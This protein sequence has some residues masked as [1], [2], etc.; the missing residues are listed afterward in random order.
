M[1]EPGS[2]TVAVSIASSVAASIFRGGGG[3]SDQQRKRERVARN[4]RGKGLSETE[5]ER[6]FDCCTAQGIDNCTNERARACV[7]SVTERDPGAPDPVPTGKTG[8]EIP[9][10]VGSIFDIVKVRAPTPRPPIRRPGVPTTEPVIRPRPRIPAPPEPEMVPPEGPTVPRGPDLNPIPDIFFPGRQRPSTF[11]STR[12][13]TP[14]PQAE[15]DFKPGPAPDVPD[16]V[17]PPPARRRLPQPGKT[18]QP[19]RQRP[20]TQRQAP[21]PGRTP[22]RSPSAP[23]RVPARVPA[24]RLAE[25]GLVAGTA[26]IAGQQLARSQARTP[27]RDLARDLRPELAPGRQP[28]PR[29]RSRERRRVCEKEAELPRVVCV[30]G[31]YRESRNDVEFIPWTERDCSTGEFI[32][33]LRRETT[34]QRVT[35]EILQ[36]IF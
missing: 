33:D 36:R 9:A 24:A 7:A 6:A 23:A 21:S 16:E 20:G 26:A 2:T 35:R 3:K 14:Q 13:P 10:A 1:A 8:R 17:L 18:A 30:D 5:L 28:Q 11:P 12:E 27:R 4:A 15:P 32:R 34:T 25:L 29:P 31:L 19:G 22:A